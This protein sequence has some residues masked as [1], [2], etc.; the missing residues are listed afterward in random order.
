[1][2]DADEWDFYP[3]RIDDY[4]ASI[5]LNLRYDGSEP[6]PGATT[7]YRV[8]LPMREPGDHGVG[9]AAEAAA[10]NMFEELVAQR[11]SDGELIYV[12]R[13]RSRADWELVFYG[14]ADRSA[15]LQAV[16]DVFV[17]RLTY[18][19]VRT[20]PDW[21]YYRELLLPD[22][23]RRRWMHD[24]RLV[25][26]LAREGDS[27]AMPRRVD[28][29]AHFADAA[30]RDRFVTAAV[31]AGFTLQ[32]AAEVK[33]KPLPFGAQVYRVD[34]VELEHIHDVVIQLVE[35]AAADGGEYDGWETAV[36]LAS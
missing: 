6:P 36:T 18:L 26:V 31:Q 1:M 28:H 32:R 17:D 9:T 3:C 25:D 21:G 5:V 12:G 19:D 11:A 30:A 34:A 13:I 33:D 7:L 15:A 20:D 27:L 29:W 22:A 4:A 8:R 10:M 35:L 16:R 14:P 2:A 24:R 23:E